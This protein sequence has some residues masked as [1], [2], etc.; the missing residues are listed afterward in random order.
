MKVKNIKV[1]KRRA[2]ELI[3]R[4]IELTRQGEYELAR[5]YVNLALRYS[6][7][8]KFKIPRKYKRLICRKCHIP[9]I[10]GLTE[11]R[12]IKNKV[13]VRTCLLCGWVRRY[14]LKRIDKESK[15]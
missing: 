4:A 6:S 11:R 10:I 7:K 13:L 3:E 12:R 15:G 1:Y 14:Q 5:E 9:L 2:I 8:L